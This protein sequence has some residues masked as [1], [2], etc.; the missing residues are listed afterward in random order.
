[1]ETVNTDFF[2]LYWGDGIDRP[3]DASFE[4]MQDCKSIE[5]AERSVVRK[6]K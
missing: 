2:A 6:L 1:M 4:Y 5:R 3:L